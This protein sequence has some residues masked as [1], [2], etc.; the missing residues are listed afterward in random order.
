MNEEMEMEEI[1][2][3][4]P[5]DPAGF[6]NLYKNIARKL[7]DIV[8][9]EN[10]IRDRKA[11][12]LYYHDRTPV[13][14]SLSALLQILPDIIV[15]PTTEAQICRIVRLASKE[16]VAIIPKGQGTGVFSASLPVQ[17]GI[18][19]D[20]SLMNNVIEIDRGN[21]IAVVEAGTS[22]IKL[23]QDLV[24]EGTTLGIHPFRPNSTVGG[25][26]NSGEISFGSY[27][28]GSTRE[29][30]RSLRVVLPNGKIVDTGFQKVLSN[31]SGYD[32]NS[33]FHG[34]EG[35]F[36]V[37]TG[38]TFNLRRLPPK[39]K[40]L[41]YTFTS[42]KDMGG[43]IK[44][45]IKSE[46][47]P[48]NIGF[49]NQNH[50]KYVKK[51]SKDAPLPTYVVDIIYEGSE[52]EIMKYEKATDNLI[53]GN[54]GTKHPAGIDPMWID[55]SYSYKVKL[56]GAA[57]VPHE[58]LVPVQNIEK[59]FNGIDELS[60]KLR[61]N[62]GIVGSI[63]D[64]NTVSVVSYFSNNESKTAKF[65]VLM[66]FMKN[67]NKLSYELEG[68]PTGIDIFFNSNLKKM[69]GTEGLELMRMMKNAIDPYNIMNPGKITEAR[70]IYGTPYPEIT[71]GMGIKTMLAV[72]KI[73][74]RKEI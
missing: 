13:P 73:L 66:G 16:G 54:R 9:S 36:G 11:R 49:A 41:I 6:G 63:P 19:I 48:T 64:K 55:V 15:K 58:I 2:D 22:W 18:V 52:K 29:L 20:M 37:V 56:A 1:Y 39:T 51:M 43:L 68:R 8:S 25:W 67:L 27:K 60:K 33:L 57:T 47:T 50:F 45:L 40:H 21:M 34:S 62:S 26:I 3:D 23:H 31:M 59:A 38:I 35:T 17:G 10:V 71:S 65:M 5:I 14:R 61:V 7:D 69:H 32:L 46:L 28:Y 44:R 70:T 74:P 4:E 53:I 12:L 24:A 30:I 72:R 42:L